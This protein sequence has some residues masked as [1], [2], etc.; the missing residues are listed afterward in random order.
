MNIKRENAIVEIIAFPN[1]V[2]PLSWIKKFKAVL[3]QKN[4]RFFRS[5]NDN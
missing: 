2:L 3:K 1:F 5:L 4:R